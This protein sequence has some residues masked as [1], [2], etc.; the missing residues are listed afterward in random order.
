MPQSRSWIEKQFGRFDWQD[1]PKHRGAIIIPR[2]WIL[3]NTTRIE[4]AFALRDGLGR[5]LSSIPCHKLLAPLLMAVLVDLQDR[6]LCH[7]INTFDGCFVP[8]HMSWDPARSLSHHSWG[9]AVDVNAHLF[10][11]ASRGK[12]DAQLIAAF[13]RRGFEWGGDWSTPDP[14]HFEI[15]SVQKP[16]STGEGEAMSVLSKILDEVAVTLGDLAKRAVVESVQ[17]VSLR[18]PDEDELAARML[19]K[20]RIKAWVRKQPPADQE[21][22]RRAAAIFAS[23]ALETIHK[24]LRLQL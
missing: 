7:L 12:Q 18:L 5:P 3:A 19:G 8:R 4:P 9:I 14:M 23:A 20:P 11:Y 21:V 22:I 17:A 13:R 16:A 2:E 6:V 10:P 24:E 15:V 1:D